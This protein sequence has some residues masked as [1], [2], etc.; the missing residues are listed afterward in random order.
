MGSPTQSSNQLSFT[1]LLLNI[2]PQSP[3]FHPIFTFII[4]ILKTG[5]EVEIVSSIRVFLS[6]NEGGQIAQEERL[7]RMKTVVE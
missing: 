7:K 1:P 5:S 6:G 4:F 2:L 3:D